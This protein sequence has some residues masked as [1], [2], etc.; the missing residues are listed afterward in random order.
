MTVETPHAPARDAAPGAAGTNPFDEAQWSTPYG[1]PPFE[2][3][4]PEHF[5][6]A[7]AKALAAHQAEIAAIAADDRA[8]SFDNTIA[9]MERAG[10]DLDRVA[11]TFFNL[12]G[13]H[14]NPALQAIERDI[15]PK[16]A[17]H[18]SAIYLNA[19]LWARIARVDADA[20][21]LGEEERRVLDRYRTRFRRAGADLAPE[22]KERVAEIAS[23]MAVL[24]TRF[25]QNLLAD[26]SGF[27]LPLDGEDDLAGLPEF[28][29]EAAAEAAT[30]RGGGNSH[31]ITLSRSLVDPFLVFSTRR[32]LRERA[33]EAWTHRGE[34]GGETDNRAIITEIVAL[35]AE[36]ARLLGFESFAHF[37]L[38]DTMAGSPD[39]AMQ[40]L[41]E[42]WAPARQRAAKERG[43]L[44][45]LVQADGGNFTIQAHDWRHYAE[46]LRR[47][48][49]DIDESEIKPYLSLEGVIQAS[50]DTASRLFGLRFEEVRDVPRYHADL[51]IWAVTNAD[52]SPVGLFLGD[53][54][55]RASKR[56]GA[57]MSAFRSQERLSG[58]IKP[59]IVN[60]MNFA[61]APKGEPTLLS[62][63]DARTL[64]HEFGHAL[65]G[66]L[67]DVTYPLLSGTSVSGD[68]VELPSQLYE[69]WLE[70]PEVLRQHARHY[71]TGAPMPED[72]LS[73]LLA[74][75][76]FN[77][78]F[79]TVEYTASAIVDMT[80]H[81]SAA[82]EA[83]LDVLAFEADA[84]RRI[85]MPA[86]ITM[87]HRSPHFAHIFSGD[88][89]A[90]G[91]YS[92]IWSE[93]LD[94]DAF[95][96]F[97]EAGDIFDPETAARLRRFV[98]GA[99]NLRDPREAYTAFRG[100]L[101]S[102][103]PLL[104]KR[105]LVQAAA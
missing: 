83:G 102:I 1:L 79:S 9:A 40:L 94:A 101:P 74:A 90:A 85:A 84:L 56:S 49:H 50:F 24:G 45:A 46:K 65:H 37:K 61:K 80:L 76:T 93:V 67:S 96:A 58:D 43:Q 15:G 103:D 62:F 12:T 57:W 2:R 17:R 3:I 16:L 86:E 32:D 73:R 81:L 38:D 26:E 23:R 35:R 27:S 5:G 25:S 69:H 98:Y 75:R 11:S 14:T 48:E 72:L 89:Y 66:L 95:D 18:G 41:R 53:Y 33:Y 64:F 13:S 59:I 42:V 92:Y 99:G 31:V 8:S 71:R 87:R 54:F 91:Y 22:P 47:A 39:A 20:E 78:G 88:G 97:R 104:K 52:G 82:G 29:R 21:H 70:Q 105:G 44:Q 68:F 55:A 19:D 4:A 51:R 7:F 36:R 34:G 28:L 100:R 6:P 30:E 10:Q 60:V 63:D 77:Q